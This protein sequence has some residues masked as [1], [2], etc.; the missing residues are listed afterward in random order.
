M[1]DWI[2]IIKEAEKQELITPEEAV[3]LRKEHELLKTGFAV[4]ATGK[5]VKKTIKKV[6]PKSLKKFFK[7][8]KER[9]TMKNFATETRPGR[10]LKWVG[11]NPVTLVALAMGA[12][13]GGM[14]AKAMAAPVK[15]RINYAAMKTE[16]GRI[17]PETMKKNNEKDIK[18][19][20][21]SVAQLAPAVASNPLV[22]AVLVR[23]N[24]DMPHEQHY[25][26]IQALSQIQKNVAEQRTPGAM[27][28]TSAITGPAIQQTTKEVA[29]VL[30]GSK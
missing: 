27:H 21:G 19:I 29:K 6:K 26:A 22:M 24:I 18:R 17:S 4:K 25:T 7:G 14:A 16:L 13:L 20:Y 1:Q 23:D 2:A 3:V 12:E 9:Y 11:D 15:S 30:A 10:V 5:A 28:M 8:I